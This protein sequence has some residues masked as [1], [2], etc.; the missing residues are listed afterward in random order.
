MCSLSVGENIS[1]TRK[2]KKDINVKKEKSTRIMQLFKTEREE[3]IHRMY[4]EN[5]KFPAPAVTVLF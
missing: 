2:F 4:T 1:E 5:E 3:V